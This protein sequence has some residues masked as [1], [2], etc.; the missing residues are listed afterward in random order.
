M[1]RA[2]TFGIVGGSGNTARA[3]AEELRRS[4]ENPIV[5]G[6]RNLL[7]ST[8][9]ANKLGGGVSATR[10]DVFDR[11]S[12]E[13]LCEQCAVVVNGDDSYGRFRRMVGQCN[14]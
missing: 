7:A 10:V 1:N 6:G 13:E 2:A 3:V 11:G 14:A 9:A 5:L 8:D 4:T 12:L